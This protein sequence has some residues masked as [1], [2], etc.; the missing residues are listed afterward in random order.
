MQPRQ[1]W[2]ANE[3][4]PLVHPHVDD[5][6]VFHIV[7]ANNMPA[8]ILALNGTTMDRVRGG[9][10]GSALGVRRIHVHGYVEDLRA[11]YGTMRISV[12]PLRWGAGVK[13]KI[14]SAMKYGVPVVCTAVSTEG[15]FMENRANA[16]VTAESDATAF[17]QSVVELYNDEN[18]WSRVRS[19][20]LD[21][22]R[23][24]FSL[25]NAAEGMAQMLTL[26]LQGEDRAS[27]KID[28]G[29]RALSL[30]RCNA[31]AR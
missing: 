31:A 7:G 9:K 2:F 24:Y 21:N 18:L 16:M 27:R 1:L 13:G 22:V 30:S 4:L 29:T 23:T 14:N 12:A 17:A 3:I 20:G 25:S 10:T 19:G 8:E 15:M 28:L 6:F 5:S 26:A 11:L